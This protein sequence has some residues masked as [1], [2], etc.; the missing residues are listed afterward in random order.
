MNPLVSVIVA[1][2]R[3]DTVLRNALYSLANQ[4][5]SE[6][7]IVLVDDNDAEFWNKK[8][9]IIVDEFKKSIHLL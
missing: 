7:E 1:T 8:V 5:Y 9:K 6:L 4:S 3:R 2:Y